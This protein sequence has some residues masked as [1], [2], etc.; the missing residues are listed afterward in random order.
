MGLLNNNGP[1]MSRRS[2]GN[3][4]GMDALDVFMSSSPQHYEKYEK[5]KEEPED[6]VPSSANADDVVDERE[7]TYTDELEKSEEDSVDDTIE[8]AEQVDVEV[9]VYDTQNIDEATNEILRG[10]NLN[11]ASAVPDDMEF[12][13]NAVAAALGCSVQSIRNYCNTYDKFL[14]VE[15][16]VTGIRRFRMK[17]IRKLKKIITVK[18]ERGYTTQQ[19]ITFLENDG[20]NEL[21][22][23]DEERINAL[24]QSVADTV[25]DKLVD[26]IGKSGVMDHFTEKEK[27]LLLHQEEV[28]AALELRKTEMQQ[29][30]KSL[31]EKLDE[32]SKKEEKIEMFLDSFSEE[33][34]KKATAD[35]Q[36]I[37]EL[38]RKIQEAAIQ[39][40]ELRK[41]KD[42][43]IAT[44]EEQVEKAQKKRRFFFRK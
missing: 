26:Y 34:M 43:Y 14:N 20:K 17:D 16:T 22:V 38:E 42:E 8:A 23:T 37:E 36:H 10:L 5:F 21:I 41:A 33:R 4:S 39:T 11:T 12:G 3:N 30:E 7:A 40:E 19:M 13:T 31:N 25:F 29:F 18:R 28:S 27:E 2:T 24:A 15:M 6:P 44:L 35:K 9:E 32:L 1:I